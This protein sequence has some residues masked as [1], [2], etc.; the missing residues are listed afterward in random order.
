[1]RLAN[2]IP[3]DAKVANDRDPRDDSDADVID[4]A[5][6]NAFPAVARPG[7]TSDAMGMVAG[8][9]IVA[10]L[11]AIT[12]WSMSSARLPDPEG[13]G[14]S[15]VAP[16]VEQPAGEVLPQPDTVIVEPAPI[17]ADPAPAPVLA[18]E[19]GTMP[20]MNPYNNPTVVYDC[21]LAVTSL[22]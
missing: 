22:G 17:M 16:V 21:P 8:I 4:L 10:G 7:G 1:M 6:R 14:G 15:Q 12:L 19:P 20:T 5:Q 13:V 11:G 9:A 18:A 2:R 3:Q